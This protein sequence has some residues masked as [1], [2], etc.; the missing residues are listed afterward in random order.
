MRPTTLTS[1]QE[2]QTALD[3]KAKESP[4]VRLY[5]LYDKVCRKNVLV[6]A[7]ER[8]KANQSSDG[9]TCIGWRS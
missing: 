1:V 3:A 9:I 2:L 7:P 5:A 8:R 6:Y 4:D